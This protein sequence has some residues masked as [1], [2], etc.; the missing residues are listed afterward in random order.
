MSVFTEAEIP[1]SIQKELDALNEKIDKLNEQIYNAEDAGNQLRADNLKMRRQE[2][3][4]LLLET[5]N[6]GKESVPE[7][8]SGPGPPTRNKFKSIAEG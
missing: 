2:L 6:R 1:R 4:D 3:Y 7:I 5:S 8:K